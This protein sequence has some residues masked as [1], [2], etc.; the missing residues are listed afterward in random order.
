M[1]DNQAPATPCSAGF[2]NRAAHDLRACFRAGRTVPD[3]I[4]EDLE[5]TLPEIPDPIAEHLEMLQVQAQRG[6]RLVVD[7]CEY[8]DAGRTPLV[9]EPVPCKELLGRVAARTVPEG[10]DMVIEDTGAI[11]MAEDQAL[12]RVVDLILQNAVQHHAAAPGRLW[13]SARRQGDAGV[14]TI[15]DD[16]PG[17][18]ED[19]RGEVFEPL[20][21]L[22]ARDAGGGSG[23]GLSIARQLLTA[24]DGE[25]AAAARPEG[26]G[27]RITVKLPV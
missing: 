15:D 14:I 5:A 21:T 8:L 12:E 17:I 22:R 13:L 3:W 11:V 4:R 26:P 2:L 19:R 25:I 23:L 9:P 20:K 27:T 18:P 7:L 1:P 10:W 16:G 24:M 6:D